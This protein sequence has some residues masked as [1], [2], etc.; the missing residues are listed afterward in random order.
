MDFNDTNESG[1]TDGSDDDSVAGS[2]MV[3]LSAGSLRMGQCLYSCNG[4]YITL[5]SSQYFSE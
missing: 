5:G 4:S 3:D 1:C 2:M